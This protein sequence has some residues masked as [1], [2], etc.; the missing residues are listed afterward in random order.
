MLR[1]TPNLKD[2]LFKSGSK[3]KGGVEDD[4]NHFGGRA[5]STQGLNKLQKLKIEAFHGLRAEL[6]FVRFILASAPLLLKIILLVHESVHEREYLK[7]SEELM[8]FPRSSPKLEIICE[9]PKQA[10]R[11]LH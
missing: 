2:L 10:K 1:S 4:V 7:I 9:L 11:V 8:G 6:L 5:Y 3:M